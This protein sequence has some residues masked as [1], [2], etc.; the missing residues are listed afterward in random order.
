MA[1]WESLGVDTQEGYD[2]EKLDHGFTRR[3]S[4]REDGRRTHKKD[5]MYIVIAFVLT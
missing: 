3:I 4:C 5:L 1:Q 2:V